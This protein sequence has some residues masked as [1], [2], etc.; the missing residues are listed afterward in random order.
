MKFVLPVLEGVTDYRVTSPFG[1]RTYTLN[2]KV[3]SDNHSG[4][5]LGHQARILAPAEGL[6][7]DIR[8]S[9]SLSQSAAIMA[10]TLRG[11][12]SGNYI[13]LL[14]GDGLVSIHKHIAQNTFLVKVGDIVKISTPLA[15]S[16]RTGKATG[17]HD[18]FEIKIG[19]PNGPSVDPLPYLQGKKKIA[20]YV[21]PPKPIAIQEVDG[22]KL[23]VKVSELNYRST[24][25]GNI[26]GQLPN[27]CSLPL[28]GITEPVKGYKWAKVLYRDTVVYCAIDPKWNTTTEGKLVEKLVYKPLTKTLTD[29]EVTIALTVAPTP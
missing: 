24:P 10:G 5:D 25:N 2:N 18:H 13:Y 3:V 19:G 20:P 23:T 29:G 28:I 27:A 9:V 11:L 15:T 7:I 14:H 21:A 6:V 1:P 26:L 12:D 4:I 8:N 17:I 16:G 22:P